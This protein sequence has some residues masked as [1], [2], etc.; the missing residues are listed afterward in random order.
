[1]EVKLKVE[2]LTCLINW[3]LYVDIG[4]VSPITDIASLITSSYFLY[5]PWTVFNMGTEKNFS[6]I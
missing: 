4:W 1:M 2:R 5:V 3:F 6:Q